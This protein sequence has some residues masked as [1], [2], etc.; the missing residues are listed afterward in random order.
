MFGD[1]VRDCQVL[2]ASGGAGGV[3]VL[4]A[5]SSDGSRK[6]LLVADYRSGLRKLAVDVA[7][8][9]PDAE[10]EVAVHDHERDLEIVKLR[11][12]GGRLVMP[13]RDANSAAFFV[14]F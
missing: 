7:G 1:F 6:E 4:A 9:S 11:L 14:K 13:K 2:C 3:T 12:D 10:C 5:K 8:V